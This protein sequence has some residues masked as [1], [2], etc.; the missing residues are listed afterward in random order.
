[1][2]QSHHSHVIR[3]SLESWMGRSGGFVAL[4]PRFS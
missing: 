2:S 3:Q 4:T 1:M